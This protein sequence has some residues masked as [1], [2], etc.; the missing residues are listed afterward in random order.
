MSPKRPP[1]PSDA[2]PRKRAKRSSLDQPSPTSPSSAH[3]VVAD[4][5]NSGLSIVIASTVRPV[6][7]QS[8]T[9]EEIDEALKS[10]FQ[11]GGHP[12]EVDVSDAEWRDVAKQL[13]CCVQCEGKGELCSAA[14][15]TELVCDACQRAHKGCSIGI[16]YRYRLFANQFQ[17]SLHWA[18]QEFD[19]R[20]PRLNSRSY[21][22]YHQSSPFFTSL[23]E[24]IQYA[25]RSADP[26]PASSE[27][28]GP[29][30]RGR[31]VKSSTLPSPSPR[32]PR[33]VA[34][35]GLLYEPRAPGSRSSPRK[36]NTTA[37]AVVGRP[38][39]LSPSS[40]PVT[41]SSRSNE[42]RVVRGP[43]ICIPPPA[44]RRPASPIPSL[45]PP[46]PLRV[47]GVTV[48]P[49]SEL[50]QELEAFKATEA[51]NAAE[52]RACFFKEQKDAR[53]AAAETKRRLEAEQQRREQRVVKEH[54][55]EDMREKEQAE[56][57]A[58]HHRRVVAAQQQGQQAGLSTSHSLTSRVTTSRLGAPATSP[59][60]LS[61]P[62]ILL[63]EDAPARPSLLPCSTPNPPPPT[64]PTLDLPPAPSPAPSV[65]SPSFS[66]MA[67]PPV[68][69]P[70]HWSP[71]H[72]RTWSPSRAFERHG[73]DGHVYHR[74][75][76]A[77]ASGR[78]PVVTDLRDA[79]GDSHW[80][81]LPHPV[82]WDPLPPMPILR[83]NDIGALQQEL[84]DMQRRL[85]ST[86]LD[87]ETERAH[88]RMAAVQTRHLEAQLADLCCLN[89]EQERIL[90]NRQ[91]EYELLQGEVKTLADSAAASA[92]S[93]AQAKA[94]KA[95]LVPGYPDP[96]ARIKD[97][98]DVLSRYEVELR[99]SE[100]GR[101]EAVDRAIR[102]EVE[103]GNTSQ[104]IHDLM[105]TCELLRQRA[106]SAEDSASSLRKSNLDLVA[107]LGGSYSLGGA[108]ETNA[109][110][111]AE[112]ER[113]CQE[114]SQLSNAFRRLESAAPH[115]FCDSQDQL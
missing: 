56:K 113:Y 103:I 11:L 66:P 111:R 29:P 16:A 28:V 19:A 75:H 46:V 61:P 93:A 70:D 76:V 27:P 67:A 48:P 57:D 33:P 6:S 65:H 107:Q 32:S 4:V 78:D 106:C 110:L 37:Q 100:Q 30:G 34:P 109:L 68:D 85:N 102:H 3:A 96:A 40:V 79:Y 43:T 71:V 115:P 10:I 14:S 31:I 90:K 51:Q 73:V 17:A 15:G 45:T 24:A 87:L 41:S 104:L 114:L 54:W 39:V 72:P 1:S 98:E 77:I 21:N 8:A 99:N 62:P 80:L 35:F 49:G 58:H 89:S 97:L 69:L 64:E 82:R 20:M 91:V 81:E 25:T 22:L 13:N 18:R 94:Y 12:F 74:A 92:A 55:Q 52:S 44:A 50:E 83:N 47:G 53:L 2:S 60:P 86:Q 108:S 63:P 84:L 36:S 95:L 105:G 9:S 5:S 112:V 26:S 88:N 23:E 101:G 38:S 7:W 42:V 59:K